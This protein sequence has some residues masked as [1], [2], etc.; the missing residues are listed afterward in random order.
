ML[1][2]SL[3]VHGFK[4]KNRRFLMLFRA[5]FDGFFS[6]IFRIFSGSPELS[7]FGP[8]SLSRREISL[9]GRRAPQEPTGRRACMTVKPDSWPFPGSWR[10]FDIRE[11]SEYV[12]EDKIAIWG[13]SDEGMRKREEI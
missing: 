7:L 11:A 10:P 8:F 12:L 5:F 13:G 9:R 1:A 6:K 3:S 4:P 2:V